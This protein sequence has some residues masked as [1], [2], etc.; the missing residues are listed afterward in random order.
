MPRKNELKKLLGFDP[1]ARGPRNDGHMPVLRKRPYLK[2]RTGAI[3]GSFNIAYEQAA[4]CTTLWGALKIMREWADEELREPGRKKLTPE[5]VQRLE[6]LGRIGWSAYH[7]AE[8]S[9]QMVGVKLAKST[10]HGVIGSL[11]AR[12]HVLGAEPDLRHRA[13]CVP[14]KPSDLP[15]EI[16]KMDE[17]DLRQKN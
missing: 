1:N 11:W 8:N 5:I 12:G 15:E 6:E 10:V 4:M 2:E 14:G 16:R 17:R 7:I 3:A 13:A 9:E